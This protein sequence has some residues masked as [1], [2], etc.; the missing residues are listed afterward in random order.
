M[1]TYTE[2]YFGFVSNALR[3]HLDIEIIEPLRQKNASYR[4]LVNMRQKEGDV[5]RQRISEIT[6]DIRIINLIQNG[7]A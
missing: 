4:S 5:F 6:D 7:S 3:I 2:E 1:R